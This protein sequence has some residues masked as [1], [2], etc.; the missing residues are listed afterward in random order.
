MSSSRDNSLLNSINILAT[1]S[2]ENPTSVGSLLEKLA[3]KKP[4]N[5][6]ILFEDRILTSK[7]VN[8]TAN[9]YA[10]LLLSRGFKKEDTI[11]LIMDN[12]PEYLIIHAGLAKIGV[13]PALINSNLKGKI[14]THAINI[15][16][17]KAVILGHE[18]AEEYDKI[19][20]NL[21]FNDP[22]T[23]F[24]EKEGKNID[25]P[26]YMEDL[27]PLLKTASDKNPVVNPPMNIND[28][29]EFIFTSGTTGMPKATVIR[30]KK[31]IQLAHGAG[32]ICMQ[33]IPNDVIYCCLPL[34]HNNGINIAW[35]ASI[36]HEATIALRRKFSATNFWDDIRKFNATRFVYVGEL[37]RYL[38]NQPIKPDDGDNPLE[39][40]L[41]NGMRADYWEDFQKR[42]TIERIVESYGATEGVGGLINIEGIP[43]MIGQLT[44]T[45]GRIG[46]VARYNVEEGD[47]IRDEDGFLQK[48]NVGEQGMFL[49]EINEKNPFP[50]YKGNKDA[51]NEKIMEGAFKPGDKYFISGDLMELHENDYVSF[52]DR[53][54]DTFRWKGEL[55]ST[56]QV[57][58]MI[59]GFGGIEDC[60]V[61]G[62]S[63]KGTEGRAGMAALTLIP[64]RD[65]DWS[66]FT[67]Y[68][69]ETVPVY[70]RP[71]FVRIC[72]ERST[73][74]TFKL[75][76]TNLQKEGFD[77][78]LI[79]ESLYFLHPEKKTYIP[80]TKDLYGE[81]Q[82]GKLRF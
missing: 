3:E 10:N 11:V 61:Y 8:E 56:N 70:A 47:Y 19:S 50:G 65:F 6:L 66:K 63:V 14:L 68:I 4:D 21:Q 57:A 55:V 43:G 27:E 38:N 40:M 29:L 7:E 45:A 31:W 26:D 18:L 9:R 13:V 16:K 64:S 30:H 71:Y 39:V 52:V 62:V 23:V 69:T 77:P 48:C 35:A 15:S 44:N 24:L 2:E 42:F 75:V 54:G 60:N 58:D 12:R 37:C 72:D 1:L 53:L 34:Y 33:M 5:N 81:I 36:I 78:D 82:S 76:K 49:A 20:A 79:S 17:A 73:T 46:E 51:T 25:A 32:G 59:N 28:T 41:G 80:L 22:G 74:S 67:D